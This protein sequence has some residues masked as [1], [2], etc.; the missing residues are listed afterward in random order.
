M[1]THEFILVLQTPQGDYE[2]LENA[3]FEA[4]CD[5][6]TLSSRNGIVYLNFDREADDLE[7]AVVS[8]IRQVE[9]TK[10][11]LVVRR[12]EPSDLVTSAEIARRL[13]RSRQSVQQLIAGS[14]GDG[15]FP[16]PVAGVTAK[17]MLWSWQDIMEWLINKDKLEDKSVYDNA[18][19]L[20]Q[21]NESLGVRKDDNQIR[22]IR[23]IAKLLG[24]K[25]GFNEF[26]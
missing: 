24:K 7:S 14:R 2:Q 4:G 25:R 10:L 15:D 12:V 17:T 21:L 3:L 18:V 11:N 9:Q 26:A 19:T 16:L 1:K 5:D 8:A 22:N 23:R 13:G 20:K 6:A